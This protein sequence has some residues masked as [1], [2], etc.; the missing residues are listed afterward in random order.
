MFYWQ[1]VI[2]ASIASAILAAGSV[3]F[4][5]RDKR[6]LMQSVTDIDRA[7]PCTPKPPPARNPPPPFGPPSR[8]PNTAAPKAS[9]DHFAV[10]TDRENIS[11]SIAGLQRI[12]AFR[13]VYRV[14]GTG[15]HRIAYATNQVL[16]WAYKAK[17]DVYEVNVELCELYMTE[18]GQHYF[19]TADIPSPV[20]IYKG[21]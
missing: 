17:P 3:I 9:A 18:D 19:K 1:E 16:A 13:I 6:R 15:R 21:E 20:S 5:K 12:L 4:Y 7:K 14:K 2:F 10:E 8:S 11:V